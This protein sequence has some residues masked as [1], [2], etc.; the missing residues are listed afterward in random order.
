MSSRILPIISMSLLTTLANTAVVSA[1]QGDSILTNNVVELR[2][3]FSP[4]G[5][6]HPGISC[7]AETL[8][9]MREKVLAGVS[10]WVDYFEGMRRTR[11]ANL[12]QRPR[13]VRQITNDGGIGAFSQ[14]A[15]LAWAHTILYVVTGNEEYRK[16]PV[17]IIR[18]VWLPHG[19]ELLSKVLC[20]QPHQD[21]QVRLYHLHRR[22]HPAGDHA[23]R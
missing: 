5:F 11:F 7:N 13:L 20:R 12:N 23:E 14:D 8:A 19:R 1:Q 21:R 4:Q 9:V 16:T 15:H 18:M 22:G 2:E 6:V 17:E 3:T 10:P